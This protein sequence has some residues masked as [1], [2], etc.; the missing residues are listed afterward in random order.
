MYL[1]ADNGN[2]KQGFH[3]W[4]G[5]QWRGLYN[6]TTTTGTIT[7]L[8]CNEAI[9]TPSVYTSGVTYTGIVTIPYVGGNTG[10]Y[11]AQTIG[12]VNGLTLSLQAGNFELGGGNMVFSVSGTPTV[13]SPTPTSFSI[14]VGGQS[15]TIQVGGGNLKVGEIIAVSY[16]IPKTQADLSSFNLNDYVTT[17]SLTPLP[18]IDGLQMSLVGATL[19]NYY[20][21]KLYNFSGS[22]KTITYTLN[23]LLAVQYEDGTEVSINNG[24]SI[25][26][27]NGDVLWSSVTPDVMTLNLNFNNGSADRLYELKLWGMEIGSNRKIIL[28]A[29]RIF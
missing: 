10:S 12:P 19:N 23:E 3:Y 14:T 26:L 15:C 21:P 25:S 27:G 5:V 22:T 28:T 20:L 24:S 9:L 16:T 6:T 18:V 2:Y 13:S 17:N 8:S 1:I 11:A 7:N 29:R 4:D